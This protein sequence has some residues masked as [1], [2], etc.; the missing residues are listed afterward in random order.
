MRSFATG[1][2][3]LTTYLDG[4]DGRQHD[5]LTVNSLS[6]VSLNPPLVSVCLRSDCSMLSDLLATRAWAI[7]ILDVGGADLARTFARNRESRRSAL[8]NLA[9]TPTRHTGALV[10]DAPGWLEC[11]L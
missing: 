7:S 2:C 8:S 10:L 3:V 5:A 6:A 1:V 11:A 4:P 9:T